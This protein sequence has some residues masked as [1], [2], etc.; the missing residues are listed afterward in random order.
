MRL[1]EIEP[2]TG[3]EQRVKQLKANAKAT[4][5]RAAQMQ[6][7]ADVNAE[8]LGLQRS[9]QKLALLQRKAAGTTIRPNA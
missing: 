2:S 8:R 7:Q 1:E 3:A 9:Q 4:K 6:A 5:D